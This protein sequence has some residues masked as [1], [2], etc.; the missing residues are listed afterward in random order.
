MFENST[1][2]NFFV[3]CFCGSLQFMLYQIAASCR[4]KTLSN[5][6]FTLDFYRKIPIIRDW[7]KSIGG[8]GGGPEQKGGGS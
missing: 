6:D 3:V 7:S 1:L 5:V 8:V 2:C 4:Q